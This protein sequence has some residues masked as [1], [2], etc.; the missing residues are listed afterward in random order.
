MFSIFSSEMNFSWFHV[1][2][3]SIDNNQFIE[4]GNY[5]LFDQVEYRF[6]LDRIKNKMQFWFDISKNNTNISFTGLSVYKPD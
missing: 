1:T 2:I 6:Y 4:Y 5:L 3:L